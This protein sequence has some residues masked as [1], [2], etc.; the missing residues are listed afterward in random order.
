M[1]EFNLIYN[2]KINYLSLY[3]FKKILLII[4]IVILIYIINNS[5]NAL[6]YK[7]SGKKYLNK[8][9]N[10]LLI[11]KSF[12]YIK[13]NL[14]KISVIIPVYNCEKSIEISLSSIRNQN[15]DNYEIILI[16]DY[17]QDNSSFI[18]NKLQKTD[19][20][21]KIIN[22]KKNMGTL[23]SRSIGVLNSKGNYIF[24]LDND[25]LFFDE[26]LFDNIYSKAERYNYD[27]I[28]FKSFE[29]LN[30]HPQIT[31]IKESYF[32]HHKK[33]I[34]IHQPELG[35]F[36]ITKN[37][38]YF[39]NDFHIWG[40]CIKSNIYKKAVNILGKKRFLFYNCWTE[41]ISILFIIF[42]IAESFIFLDKYGIFHLD[43]KTTAT[44]KLNTEHKFISELFLL[45]I[46]IEFIKNIE[47]NYKYIVQKAILIWEPKIIKNLNK[48]NKTYLNSIL[49][50]IFKFKFINIKDI[51]QIKKVYNLTYDF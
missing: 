19:F 31:E 7:I 38:N 44:Y 46:I 25:D 37:S 13:N 20:R 21:I 6:F 50:K 29:I 1:K 39:D 22:N 40:K 28:E 27:I 9:I 33:N 12:I 26:N 41:D 14:P 43:S 32:N 17:S 24:C 15:N 36:P 51:S 42:N 4:I 34:I 18:I 16:N 23:Y 49:K 8:C 5:Y 35:L 30:Y 3:Y 11:N 47:I 45:D 48:E 2:N 10:S